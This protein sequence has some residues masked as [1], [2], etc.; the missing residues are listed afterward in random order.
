[1]IFAGVDAGGSHCEAVIG[2]ESGEQLARCQGPSASVTNS[3][4]QYAADAIVA[5]VR[6]SL[7]QA[8]MDEQVASLVIGAAGAGPRKSARRFNPP[9]PV[10]P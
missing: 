4:I 3:P 5:T 10:T 6:R 9:W 7:A 2:D 8:T 1:M